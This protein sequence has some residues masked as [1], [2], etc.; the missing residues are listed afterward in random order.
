MAIHTVV[1]GIQSAFQ[2]P[3]NITVLEATMA[4]GLEIAIPR[5]QLAR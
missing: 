3:C 2:K 1:A 4:Y 5:K